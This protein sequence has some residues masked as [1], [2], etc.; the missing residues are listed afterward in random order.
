[1]GFRLD[2]A[3]K[4]NSLLPLIIA[5]LSFHAKAIDFVLQID[6]RNNFRRIVSF[7]RCQFVNEYRH[8]HVYVRQI[9]RD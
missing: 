2:T 6:I 9:F 1:M 8:L 5:I 3:T 7:V 4:Y